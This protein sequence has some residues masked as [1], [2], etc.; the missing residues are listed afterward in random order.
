MHAPRPRF[1]KRLETAGGGGG[2]GGVAVSRYE[3]SIYRSKFAVPLCCSIAF[4]FIAC[5]RGARERTQSIVVP[6]KNNTTW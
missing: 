6:V 1:T 2:G 5:V 4:M 3:M